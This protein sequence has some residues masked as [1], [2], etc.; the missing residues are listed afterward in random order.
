MNESGEQY[1]YGRMRTYLQEN[2]EL[3]VKFLVDGL[4]SDVATWRG[5]AP[6]F[7]DLTLLILETAKRDG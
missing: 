6:A 7:D 2:R 1:G 3:P 4:A 5:K